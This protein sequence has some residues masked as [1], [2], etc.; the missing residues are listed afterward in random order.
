[1]GEY[2][3]NM[4]TLGQ[5]LQT[6]EKLAETRRATLNDDKISRKDTLDIPGIGTNEDD[7]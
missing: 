4:A 2:S 6:V 5:R 1:M 7:V 3:V